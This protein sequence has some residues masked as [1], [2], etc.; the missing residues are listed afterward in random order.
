MRFSSRGGLGFN[1]GAAPVALPGPPVV[2]GLVGPV[3]RQPVQVVQ[4][5]QPMQPFVSDPITYDPSSLPWALQ[6]PQCIPNVCSPNEFDRCIGA[7][8]AQYDAFVGAGAVQP[9]T[10]TDPVMRRIQR[11]RLNPT[12]TLPVGSAIVI[13]VVVLTYTVPKSYW[14]YIEQVVFGLIPNGTN[15]YANGSGQLTWHLGINQW[16]QYEYGLTNLDQGVLSAPGIPSPSLASGI[17]INLY[18]ND[19]A[20][21][22]VDVNSATIGGGTLVATLNGYM[23]P[24]R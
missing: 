6:G 11:V 21:L 14:A 8:K 4:Q 22:I 24:M 16:Y 23:E 7:Q 20:R 2:G 12:G 1:P 18:E 19:V 5:S 15:T 17:G 13:G 3:Y 9:K 10:I